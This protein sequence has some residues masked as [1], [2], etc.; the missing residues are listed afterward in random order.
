MSNK[1]SKIKDKLTKE[2]RLVLLNEASFEERFSFKLTRLNVFV[3]GGVFS[4]FLIA[5][6][7]FI[8][9]FSPIKEYIPGYSSTSLKKKAISLIYK[10]DS[11]QTDLDRV[12]KFTE[13]IV[14]VLG[15]EE[16]EITMSLPY[17]NSEAEKEFYLKSAENKDSLKELVTTLRKELSTSYQSFFKGQ[18]D[19]L[20]NKHIATEQSMSDLHNSILEK[21]K[22]RQ[23]DTL[24]KL[25]IALKSQDQKIASL[26]KEVSL[27]AI[28]AKHSLQNLSNTNKDILKSN[29]ETSEK[30]KQEV[31]DV[32]KKEFTTQKENYIKDY[33]LKLALLENK[34]RAKNMTI[35][36][37][38]L[39]SRSSGGLK[40]GEL[41]NE[42]PFSQVDPSE[43]LLFETSK[44]DSLFRERVYRE[45]RYSLFAFNSNSN[46]T[47]FAAPVKGVIT[48]TYDAKSK[49]YAVDVAVSDKTPVLAVSNG[50]VLFASWTSDTGYVIVIEHTN[51]YISVYKHNKVVYRSQGDIVKTG[52]VIAMA[53]S[54]GTLSTGPHLH[55]EL[56]YQGYAVNPVNF[57]E[58]E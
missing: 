47:S 43:E 16:S 42:K 24:N 18:V 56:W 26:T 52:E 7:G 46:N 33:N 38:V 21:L 4:L 45:D 53:G 41:A 1:K 22:K 44:K 28:E 6:T 14:P 27:H 11:L 3:F 30:L 57:I 54:S 17:V 55:F 25:K 40:I 23:T 48:Q 20:Q 49:H 39:L 37:L 50:T 12:R 10:V 32:L 31:T 9:A 36:S 19:S 15:G 34:L 51:N 8:I 29:K 2:F 5:L 35:D 58:F 13:A